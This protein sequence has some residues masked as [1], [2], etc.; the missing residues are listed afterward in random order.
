[1]SGTEAWELFWEESSLDATTVIRFAGRLESYVPRPAPRA[2]TY[3]A[4]DLPLP[5]PH[6]RLARTLDR[7]SS[8]RAFGPGRVSARRLG[9][10]FQAFAGNARGTRVFPSAG[11]LYPLEVFCIVNAADGPAS[12]MVVCY[13]ADNHSLSPVRP[14]PPWD[15]YQGLLGF[16]LETVPQLLFVLVLFDGPMLEKYGARGGRF[17]LI[18]AGHAAQNLALR[19]EQ[20]DMVGC[21][22][23][24]TLDRPLLDLL[25]LGETAARVALAYACGHPPG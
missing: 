4:A 8:G 16:P 1:M 12:G 21:E 23:G 25:G 10:L 19:L 20:E 13:N 6:D 7:R 24:G 11:S 9:S 15:A 3:P 14:A 22:I 2:A 5:R 17:G 18:E